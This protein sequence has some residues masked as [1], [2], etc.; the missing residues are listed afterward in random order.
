MV[1]L[2]DLREGLMPADINKTIKQLLKLKGIKMV[3]VG[4]NLACMGGITPDTNKMKQL[5]AIATSIEQDF[6]IKLLIVSGGNSANYD[7]FVGTKNP[8]RINNLRLGESIYLGRETLNRK[9]IPGLFLD[10]FTLVAEAIESKTK[11]SRPYGNSGQDAFGNSPVFQD[12]G[13]MNRVLLGLGLQD[14]LVSGLT[15]LSDVHILAASSDHIALDAGNTQLKVGQEVSFSLN[16]SAL[17]SAMTS[18]YIT[19]AILD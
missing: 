2:G 10:A 4:T 13:L 9:P 7:W 3:G 5:S 18:P 14:V 11:P 1:E 15:P 19:K 16:Y 8:G 17:L 12:K 6:G